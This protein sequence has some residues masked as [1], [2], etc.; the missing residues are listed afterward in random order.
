MEEERK[1]KIIAT[2]VAPTIT[3]TLAAIIAALLAFN[4][5][6][7][8]SHLLSWFTWV[9]ALA[10]VVASGFRWLLTLS[11]PLWGMISF[12][13]VLGLLLWLAWLLGGL[14]RRARALTEAP[15]FLNYLQD[16]IDQW[17]F[18]WT[19]S[20]V[21]GSNKHRIVGLSVV[22]RNCNCGLV[23]KAPTGLRNAWAGPSDPFLECPNCFSRYP[24][25]TNLDLEAAQA[26]I[27][28]RGNLLTR[29]DKKFSKT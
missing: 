28:Y 23:K 5:I 20:Y 11:F 19:Y 26:L 10:G 21:S 9:P 13:G 17:R 25:L 2:W 15:P 3:A 6:E 4:S 27:I 18:R 7:V 16:D 12:A 1:S 24:H 29:D 8:G 22:C 14:F